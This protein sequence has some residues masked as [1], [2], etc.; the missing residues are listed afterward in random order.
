MT[1]ANELIKWSY[2][3]DGAT[4]DFS[5]TN[6]IFVAGDLQVFLDGVLQ[7]S[8]FTVSGLKNPTGGNVSF[9]V[10]P[11]AAVAVVILSKIPAIQK[12]DF[13]NGQAFDAEG[14]IE[15]SFDRDMRVIQQIKGDLAFAYRLRDDDPA[16]SLGRLPLKSAMIGNY[17][18]GDSQGDPI[19]AGPPAGTT[20]LSAYWAVLVLAADAAASR[21]LLDAAPHGYDATE[22]SPLSLIVDVS[23]GSFFNLVTGARVVNAAQVT[24]A[25]VAPSVDPRNDIIHIDRLT[26]IVGVVAGV[27]DAVPVDPAIPAGKLP[28][29]RVRLATGTTEI[30]DAIMDDYRALRQLGWRPGVAS[31]DMIQAD[32]TGLPVIDGSQ[33][34]GVGVRGFIDGLILANGT[35]ADHDI[36]VAAGVA[37]DGGDAAL[38]VQALSPLVKQIDAGPFV[39]GTNQPGNDQAQLDGANTVSFTDGGGGEDIVTIDAGTWTVT[40]LAGETL[41]IVGPDNPGTYPVISATTTTINVA[42]GSW[43]T[44][45]AASASAIHTVKINTWYHCWLIRRSDTGVVDFIFSESATAPTLPASYDQKRRIGAVLT[46]GSADIIGFHQIGDRFNWKDRVRD[47]NTTTPSGPGALFVCTVPTGLNVVLLARALADLTGTGRH[48]IFTSPDETNVVPD[49]TNS[50]FLGSGITGKVHSAFLEIITDTSAQ[51][52]QRVSSTTL[53][54]AFIVITL[55][56]I[57]PRGRNA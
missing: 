2:T 15:D 5:Y 32:S 43:S 13:V 40:P 47:L 53:W 34:T 44:A 37:Q 10:A 41:V 33:L 52:R 16:T 36:N 49:A 30:T 25:F 39:V 23:A 19:A 50:D 38:L 18:I 8:G 54:D 29:K 57:D 42:T 9:T 11:A 24:P 45:P 6:K 3:G 51:I 31:G 1:T 27:E 48:A 26:G 4:K 17:L 55:G 14:A 28:I 12:T 22:Q 46:D 7:M 35:D 20:A 21:L 56:W